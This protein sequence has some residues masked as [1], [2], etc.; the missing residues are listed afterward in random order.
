MNSISILPIELLHRRDDARSLNNSALAGLVESI[1]QI[2]LI[3]PIRVRKV[4]DGVEYEVVAGSHRFAACDLAGLREIPCIIVT[5]DDLHAELAMIDENL[6]RAEL[7]PSERAQQTARRK[8]IYEELHPETKRESTLKKGDELPSRQV[9]DSGKVDRFSAETAL[10]SGR[11][12]RAVQRDAERGERV[13][14][15]VHDMIRGTRLDTGA[16]LDK[17]KKLLPN[18]QMHAV[19]R[20]LAQERRAE[21]PKGGIAAQ[22]QPST[23]PTYDQVRAAILLLAELTAD[24]LNAICPASKHAAMYQKL[25]HLEGVFAVARGAA[26]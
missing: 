6:M 22:I 14:P 17:I 23:K 5:D 3:N 1:E 12:E 24:D 4:A 25:A 10:A 7:S 15:E 13:I 2:G 18:E 19:K 21:Q 8:T 9:G 20:D 11:S 16:Y 26:E